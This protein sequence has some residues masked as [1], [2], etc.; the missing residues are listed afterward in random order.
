MTVPCWPM[1][2]QRNVNEVTTP[3]FRPAAQAQNRSLCELHW[4]SRSAIGEHHVGGEQ[5]VDLRTEAPDR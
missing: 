5:V 1:S 3:K 4:R 2:W